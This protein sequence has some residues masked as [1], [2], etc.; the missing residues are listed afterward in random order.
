MADVQDVQWIAQIGPEVAGGSDG[1]FHSR[2]GTFLVSLGRGDEK[3]TYAWYSTTAGNQW[4][5]LPNNQMVSVSGLNT[6]QWRYVAP[7]GVSFKFLMGPGK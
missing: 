4:I 2:S 6:I 7:P 1:M 5:A 3:T